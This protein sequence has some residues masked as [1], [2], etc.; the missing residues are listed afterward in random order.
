MG[1]GIQNGIYFK[2]MEL[3][4]NKLG[5]PKIRF[6]QNSKYLIRKLNVKHS[7][8]SI[9]TEREYISSIVILET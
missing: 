8:I 1:T 7:H 6:F 5:K 4:S 3:Y 2:D 9:T